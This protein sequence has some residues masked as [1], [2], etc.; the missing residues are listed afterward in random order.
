M[1]GAGVTFDE[2]RA[3]IQA[4]TAV[5]AYGAYVV[6]VLGRTGRTPL[7]DVHYVS[8][9]LWTV[10]VAIVASIVVH[11][12]T[13]MVSPSGTRKDQRDREINQFGEHI[14]QSLVVVGAVAAL[15][16]AMAEVSYFWIANTIYLAFVL[17]AVVG[18]VAKIVTYR[19]GF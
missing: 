6:I 9:L 1:T 14:G 5:C 15:L 13:G 10:G 7:A 3:W 8:A 16:M 11:I 4:I 17:S 2:K 18:A 12:V 19:R